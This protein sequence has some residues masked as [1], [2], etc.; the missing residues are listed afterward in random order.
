M[1]DKSSVS[2]ND[3]PKSNISIIDINNKYKIESTK[4]GKKSIDEEMTKGT[5]G[6]G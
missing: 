4:T 2:L 6:K 3:S 1:A 5:H